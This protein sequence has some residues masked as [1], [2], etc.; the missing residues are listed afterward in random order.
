MVLCFIHPAIAQKKQLIK[1]QKDSIEMINQLKKE[2]YENLYPIR[3]TVDG[4]KKPSVS[5]AHLERIRVDSLIKANRYGDSLAFVTVLN[6]IQENIVL[7]EGIKNQK[8]ISKKEQ[9]AILELFLVILERYKGWI[10]AYDQGSKLNTETG[11]ILNGVIESVEH[12]IDQRDELAQENEKLK[13]ELEKYRG[14]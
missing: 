2:I 12:L 13:K 9:E 14:Y 10:V 5:R 7:I 11:Y 3:Q 8:K 1:D 4:T 6:N